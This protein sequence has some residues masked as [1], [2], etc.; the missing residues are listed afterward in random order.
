MTTLEVPYYRQQ[1]W[2]ACGPASLR[3]LLKY[4]GIS[5]SEDDVAKACKTTEL[6]TTPSQLVKG[7][8]IF[9]LDADA[10]KYEDIED[11]KHTLKSGNPVIVLLDAGMLYG[12]IQGF[13]HFMVIT[14]FDNN[15]II[16]HDPD[17]P[18]GKDVRCSI[19]RFMQA[20][21][22]LKCW[23]IKIQKVK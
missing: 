1:K 4:V 10:L 7:S 16:Y 2:Y 3:M 15:D 22:A 18:D 13:G 9:G 19:E 11:L 6:G 23:A 21:S 5:A 14:G 12:G 8:E 20:W 17:I